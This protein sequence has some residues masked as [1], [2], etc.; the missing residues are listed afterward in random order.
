MLRAVGHPTAVKP[1]A[2]LR[3]VAK[4][5]GWPIRDYRTGRK[6]AII[7]VPTAMGI[8]AVAGGVAAGL[9]FRRRRA[10]PALPMAPAHTIV[11]AARRLPTPRR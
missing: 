3:K 9:A 4:E 11:R 7:G 10:Q 2:D 5:N 6:A 1:D 8:G